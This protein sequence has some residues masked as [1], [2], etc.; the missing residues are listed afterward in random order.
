MRCIRRARVYDPTISKREL[1]DRAEF[2]DFQRGNGDPTVIRT[3]QNGMHFIDPASGGGAFDAGKV[4]GF[5]L[6]ENEAKF[7]AARLRLSESSLRGADRAKM[8]RL[9]EMLE[10]S[11][12]NQGTAIVRPNGNELQVM[13]EEMDHARQ[14]ALDPADP[15]RGHI[16][17]LQL[18]RHP[19][20]PRVAGAL[21]LQDYGRVGTPRD[22]ASQLGMEIGA[23]LMHPGRHEELGLTV[24]EARDL[25]KHYVDKLVEK[26]GTRADKIKELVNAAYP[27][28]PNQP[29]KGP[30]VNPGGQPGGAGEPGQGAPGPPNGGQEGVGQSG[31][32]DVGP[33]G[34]GKPASRSGGSD[35]PPAEANPIRRLFNRIRGKS[36]TDDAA[37]EANYS[38]LG[39]LK[40]KTVRNLSQL[41]KASP[42]TQTS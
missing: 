42:E 18:L 30:P 39:A 19:L 36:P 5:A 16:D 15:I 32:R 26:H 29:I 21:R 35:G 34:E 1:F 12:G 7:T 41:E 40:D 13:S 22:K 6:A 33:V 14:M 10:K 8:I 20:G 31:G 2:N 25:A 9:A 38:G 37:P 27:D 11:E 28:Q 23:R 3:N 4:N 24:D 17:A